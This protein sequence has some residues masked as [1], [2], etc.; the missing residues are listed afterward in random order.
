MLG[1]LFGL[2]A[3]SKAHPSQMPES[4]SVDGQ[5]LV[6]NGIGMRSKYGVKVYQVGLYLPQ[7]TQDARAA[8]SMAGNKQMRILAEREIKGSQLAAAFINGIKKNAPAEKQTV[9]FTQLNKM[10]A[11][12][13]G[14]DVPEGN[15]FAVNL[16]QGGGAAAYINDTPSGET[17]TADGLNEAIMEI[18]L[19][20]H[21]ADDHCKQGMLGA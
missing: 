18:W 20:E 11:I 16:V 6:L 5:T 10:L 1:K 12:F 15:V 4:I 21:P 3:A 19:G 14:H 7:K 17:I 8:I 9:Y 2:K 13:D